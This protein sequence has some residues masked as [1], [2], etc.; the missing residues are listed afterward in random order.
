MTLHRFTWDTS[1][2]PRACQLC[3]HGDDASGRLCCLHPEG[4][5][6]PVHV[7]RAFG[8]ACGLE[9]KHLSFPGLRAPLT[10][11]LQP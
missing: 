3:D 6:Q 4:R 9:A 11:E 8:G 10:T 5:G 2:D 1:E 7:V